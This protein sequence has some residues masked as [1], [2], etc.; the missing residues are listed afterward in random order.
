M[1]GLG[2]NSELEYDEMVEGLKGEWRDSEGR[3]FDF[4]VVYGQKP[5]Y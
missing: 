3:T 5:H 2:L 1:G 4:I